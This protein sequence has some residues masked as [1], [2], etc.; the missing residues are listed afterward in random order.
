MMTGQNRAFR[1][2]A[3]RV[4]IGLGIAA[5]ALAYL[6]AACWA[7]P[8]EDLYAAIRSNDLQ[9]VRSALARLP[10]PIT[11]LPKGQVRLP[12]FCAAFSSTP[13][14]V[15]AL[16]DAGYPA[17]EENVLGITPLFF[18]SDPRIVD[19]LISHGANVNRLCRLGNTPLDWAVRMNNT[20]A[21]ESL[22]RHGA[23]HSPGFGLVLSDKNGWTEYYKT[24]TGK[25]PA[26]GTAVFVAKLKNYRP[27]TVP[28]VEVRCDWHDASGKFVGSE[29]EVF[30]NL[31]PGEIRFVRLEAHGIPFPKSFHATAREVDSAF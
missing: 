9:K 25:T 29:R 27:T 28:Y 10:G 26:F 3:K 21:V 18:A 31:K 4:L 17:D 24:R 5:A 23:R 13:E 12:L 8:A 15:E 22:K 1:F 2:R 7:G 20:A 19:L 30:R 6:A 14:V 16:L 11:E